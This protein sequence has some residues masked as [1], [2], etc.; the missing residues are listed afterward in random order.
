MCLGTALPLPGSAKEQITLLGFAQLLLRM[1]TSESWW[2][3]EGAPSLRPG[4]LFT[5]LLCSGNFSKLLALVHYSAL[6]ATQE[7]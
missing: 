7:T 4:P 1:S 6:D 3:R 2:R 5:P